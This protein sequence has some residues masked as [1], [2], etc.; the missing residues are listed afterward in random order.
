MSAEN[1]II[2][3]IKHI[4]TEQLLQL[5]Y[6]QNRGDRFLERAFINDVQGDRERVFSDTIKKF[7]ER[8][9]GLRRIVGDSDEALKG[10][11]SMFQWLTTNV[12][13]SVL[14]EALRATGRRIVDE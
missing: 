13:G 1:R 12:G 7:H 14:S 11:L 8:D 10:A 3:A 6:F 9:G 2:D 5:E 4:P